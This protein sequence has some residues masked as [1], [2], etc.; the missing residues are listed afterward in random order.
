MPFL[1]QWKLQFTASAIFWAFFNMEFLCLS[2]KC[3]L[4]IKNKTSFCLVFQVSI[5]LQRGVWPARRSCLSSKNCIL[6]QI[7]RLLK[8]SSVILPSCSFYNS[9]VFSPLFFILPLAFEGE[10]KKKER[11]W[12]RKKS[13]S[14]E[15]LKYIFILSFMSLPNFCRNW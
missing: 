3:N 9:T 11:K 2:Q 14:Q 7:P 6:R 1:Y 8:N 10:K 5:C 13:K 15:I 4:R 12:K